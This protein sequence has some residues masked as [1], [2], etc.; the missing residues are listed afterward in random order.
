MFFHDW[1]GFIK[2]SRMNTL[3]GTDRNKVYPSMVSTVHLAAFVLELRHK[4]LLFPF[5]LAL[6]VTP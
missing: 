4:L 2:Q 3:I 1:F 6:L 5:P